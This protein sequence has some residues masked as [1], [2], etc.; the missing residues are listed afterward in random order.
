[1]GY[2]KRKK[3]EMQEEFEIEIYK[4]TD[5]SYLRKEKIAELVANKDIN[6]R[7][8]RYLEN[9]YDLVACMRM[10]KICEKYQKPNGME[11][12]LTNAESYLEKAI[13]VYLSSDERYGWTPDKMDAYYNN[14]LPEGHK[15]LIDLAM[16]M[17]KCNDGERMEIIIGEGSNSIS[18]ELANAAFNQNITNKNRNSQN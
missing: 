18:G 7:S 14:T 10:A 8:G 15:E 17:K 9:F 4:E 6:E 16:S 3:Q 1:M 12:A 11:T 2:L 13:A 5:D